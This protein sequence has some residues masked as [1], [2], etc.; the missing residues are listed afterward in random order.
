HYE[1]TRIARDGHR[2]EVSLTVSPLKG[3]DGAIVGV[4]QIA[5]DISDRKR[6]E[7][8]AAHLAAIID[9]SEDAIISKDLDGTIRSWNR[10]AERLLGYEAAEMIGTSIR[11]VIPADRQSEE[12][13]V[14]ASV[15]QG[16]VVDH[17]ETLRLRKDGSSVPISLTV[18]PIRSAAGD[19][20]GASKIMRDQTRM[21]RAERDA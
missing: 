20:I 3:E 15:R 12:D 19:I 2:V 10:A 8:G 21:R 16:S 14:L 4:S 5:R 11:R 17:F 6:L 9:S 1:T 18:S 13:D 7:R